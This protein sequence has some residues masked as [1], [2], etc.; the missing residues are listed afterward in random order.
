LA[1]GFDELR[2]HGR[3]IP[4]A[5]NDARCWSRGGGFELDQGVEAII[6]AVTDPKIPDFIAA[7]ALRE[8]RVFRRDRRFAALRTARPPEIA[9]V[10]ETHRRNELERHDESLL[11]RME[12]C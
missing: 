3:G 2:K 9:S 1:A 7:E 6:A 12:P 10:K 4:A 11:A 5:I 8:Y